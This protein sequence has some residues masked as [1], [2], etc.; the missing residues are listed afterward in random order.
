MNREIRDLYIRYGDRERE[1]DRDRE[2]YR[3]REIDRHRKISIYIY[4]CRSEKMS[5]IM[6]VY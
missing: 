1:R 2:R 3:E 6:D 5:A 4:I